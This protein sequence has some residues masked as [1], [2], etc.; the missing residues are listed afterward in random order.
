MNQVLGAHADEPFLP[1]ALSNLVSRGD[2]S[3]IFV[4]DLWFTLVEIIL[5]VNCVEGNFISAP[6]NSEIDKM[7]AP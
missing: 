4:Y 3:H 2:C 7:K 1:N 5:A 6:A